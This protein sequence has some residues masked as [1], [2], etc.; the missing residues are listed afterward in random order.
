MPQLD[1][2]QSARGIHAEHRAVHD[3]AHRIGADDGPRSSVQ[4]HFA[5]SALSDGLSG[6]HEHDVGREPQDLIEAV[7]DVNHGDRQLIP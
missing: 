6:F 5:D 3:G 4:A 7:A 1:A 2:Q